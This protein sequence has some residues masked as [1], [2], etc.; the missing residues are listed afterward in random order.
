MIPIRPLSINRTKIILSKPYISVFI[1]DW[2][3]SCQPK[4][5][6]IYSNPFPNNG[7]W[8]KYSIEP[9]NCVKRISIELPCTDV[10]PCELK[11]LIIASVISLKNGMVK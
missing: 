11:R 7:D 9:Y 10:P 2:S 5:S 3:K 8:R 4:P 1:F 6:L